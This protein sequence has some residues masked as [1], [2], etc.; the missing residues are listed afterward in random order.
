MVYNNYDLYD[1]DPKLYCF[2]G[3]IYV[4]VD[5]VYLLLHDYFTF[6]P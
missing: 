6:T 1:D 2:I 5:Y 3:I 4:Q